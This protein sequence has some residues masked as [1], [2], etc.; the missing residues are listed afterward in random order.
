MLT[1]SPDQLD[2]DLAALEQAVERVSANLLDLD[3]DSDRRFLDAATLDVERAARLQ[4]ADAEIADLWQQEKMLE[5]LL[6]RARRLRKRSWIVPQSEQELQELLHG[7]SI[8]LEGSDVPL[9]ERRLTGDARRVLRMTPFEL[10]ERMSASFEQ[11]KAVFASIAAEL[12]EVAKLSQELVAR[13][14]A[15]RAH[16]TALRTLSSEGAQAHE[17]LRGRITGEAAP[18]PLEVDTGLDGQLQHIAQLAQDGDWTT[19]HAELARWTNSMQAL[20]DRARAIVAANRAPIEN[21]NRLRGML[22]AYRAKAGRLGLVE[23]PEM[24]ELFARARAALFTAP[25][26]LDAASELVRAYQERVN[27]AQTSGGGLR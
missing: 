17:A 13:L 25:T 4:A 11:A 26:D 7:D 3:L 27:A 21:R 16:L 2:I 9:A 20:T 5:E 14:E 22:D 23:E 8:V 6:E 19:A 15:A 12:A 18:P 24:E 1:M 10:L